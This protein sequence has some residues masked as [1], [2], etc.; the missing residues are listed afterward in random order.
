[1]YITRILL[2]VFILYKICVCTHF[3]LLWLFYCCFCPLSSNQFAFY[4]QKRQDPSNPKSLSEIFNSRRE[5]GISGFMIDPTKQ[6]QAAKDAR[7]DFSETV[8]KRASLSGP[9]GRGPG[10]TKAGREH[11]DPLMIS[12]SA[13]LSRLS[14]LVATRTSSSE[15]Q[16]DRSGPLRPEAL[17][18][19]GRFARSVNEGESTKK[20]DRKLYTQRNASSRPVEDERACTKVQSLVRLIFFI[21]FL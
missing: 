20:Q 14:G 4:I 9:L 8:N 3:I 1:M 11:N 10:G 18:H 15:D 6:S 19:G 21:E 12:T 17:D 2:L 16:H 5:D 13:N 7:K